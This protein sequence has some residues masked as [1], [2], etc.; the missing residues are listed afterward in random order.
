VTYVAAY[1]LKNINPNAYEFL[2]CLKPWPQSE[3][4][5]DLFAEEKDIISQMM[6]G[7]P[8]SLMKGLETYKSQSIPEGYKNTVELDGMLFIPAVFGVDSMAV[9]SYSGLSKLPEGPEVE[10]WHG[11]LFVYYL[12]PLD[13]AFPNP[14]VEVKSYRDGKCRKDV[15]C[16][17]N[18]LKGICKECGIWVA[19]VSA[20]GDTGYSAF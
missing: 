18:K 19:A 8:E 17:I 16:E 15:I 4:V 14:V 3:Y 12:Q 1:V 9:E 10:E 2:R 13:H 7:E 6:S 5:S 20:D 11:Y